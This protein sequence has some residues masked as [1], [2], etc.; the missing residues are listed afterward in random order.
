MIEA[1]EERVDEIR[2]LVSETAHYR[3]AVE[4]LPE[5]RSSLQIEEEKFQRDRELLGGRL[6]TRRQSP[7]STPL[8]ICWLT[9]SS[10]GSQLVEAESPLIRTR[11][12]KLKRRADSRDDV[13]EEVS[14]ASATRDSVEGVPEQTSDELDKRQERLGRLRGALAERFGR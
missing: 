13:S 3:K 4:D 12:A 5:V 14:R 9:L 2:Q 10:A 7:S 11:K 6:G 8:L 1:F